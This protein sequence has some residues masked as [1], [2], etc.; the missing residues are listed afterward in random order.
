MVISVVIPCYNVARH[1][2]TV[3]EQLPSNVRHIILVNDCSRDNT[4]EKLTELS[5]VNKK[6]I[7]LT[8]AQ[9][10]GV[11]GAMITGFR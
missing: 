1:I 6:V 7:H 2:E 9:N 8:H 10:Q 5:K 3:V 11:G 4:E